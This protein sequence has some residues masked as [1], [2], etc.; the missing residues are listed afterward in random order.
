MINHTAMIWI[1]F[2]LRNFR[3]VWFSVFMVCCLILYLIKVTAIVSCLLCRLYGFI[4]VFER[5]Q[6]AELTNLMAVIRL[7]II[8]ITFMVVFIASVLVRKT[9]LFTSDGNNEEDLSDLNECWENVIGNEL[10]KL[11]IFQVLLSIG[12][13]TV[14]FEYLVTIVAKTFKLVTYPL[15][16]AFISLFQFICSIVRYRC[17][18]SWY[19]YQQ[20]FLLAW[21]VLLPS[22]ISFDLAQY[23]PDFL[24]EMD[25]HCIFLSTSK[26]NCSI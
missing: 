11:Y 26:G 18:W 15:V 14:I 24:F 7:M 4:T 10:Y 6:S 1:I 2:I 5:L 19:H 9:S 12:F 25:E 13:N 22:L 16:I 17:E 20:L 8:R 23:W 21:L 3:W